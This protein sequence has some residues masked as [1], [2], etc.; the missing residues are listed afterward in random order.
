MSGPSQTSRCRGSESFAGLKP[1]EN[2]GCHVV[3]Q[4]KCWNEVVGDVRH[5]GEGRSLSAGKMACND[6]AAGIAGRLALQPLVLHVVHVSVAVRL[7]QIRPVLLL[8][9][10]CCSR[11]PGVLIPTAIVAEAAATNYDDALRRTRVDEPL[12]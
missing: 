7:G 8:L 2:F 9:G 5:D 12:T 3:Q 10:F 1:V 4:K 6:L 11:W